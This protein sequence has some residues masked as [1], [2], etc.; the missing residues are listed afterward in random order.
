MKRR[1]NGIG[2]MKKKGDRKINKTRRNRLEALTVRS[3]MSEGETLISASICSLSLS[4]KE[5][6][7]SISQMSLILQAIFA[8][9]SISR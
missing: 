7:S 6:F 2:L 4:A 3:C 9:K 5:T 8:M 1:I